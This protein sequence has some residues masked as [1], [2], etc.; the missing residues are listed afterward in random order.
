MQL[1]FLPL[2]WRGVPV[3]SSTAIC[4]AS[5]GNNGESVSRLYLSLFSMMQETYG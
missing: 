4:Y 1:L 3:G 2:E 5:T